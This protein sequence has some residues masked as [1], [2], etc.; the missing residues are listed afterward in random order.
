M[1]WR[2]RAEHVT[3]NLNFIKNYRHE[4]SQRS[5]SWDR[6]VYSG[7]TRNV[8][9]HGN[10]DARGSEMKQMGLF[11]DER[12]PFEKLSSLE[13]LE[14]GF[15]AVKNNGG[16]AGI[17]GITI[18]DFGTRLEEE[19]VELK[20]EL[21][22]W[23]YKP[24]P[25]RGVEIPKLGKGAGVRL[26]GIPCVRDRVVQATLKL[27]LEPIL[28]PEFSDSSYGFRPG[29]N[30]RQG[31]RSCS[32]DSKIGKRICGRH[33]SVEIFRPSAPRPFNF[34]AVGVYMG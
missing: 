26:L 21:E 9:I 14:R 10:G 7:H 33:R 29:R 12:S 25:V 6:D 27:T 18:E 2:R 11:I 34:S 23:T 5:I 16:S 22:S 32:G 20:R 30:Q 28:D 19:L 4:V 24:N 1:G 31:S 15:K 8:R 3:E 13:Y 17:D